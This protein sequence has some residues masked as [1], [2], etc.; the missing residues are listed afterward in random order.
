MHINVQ[1]LTILV[2]FRTITEDM[3]I[4]MDSISDSFQ[5]ERHRSAAETDT[6]TQGGVTDLL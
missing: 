3:D 1:Y 4:L 6:Y 5:Q 2:S